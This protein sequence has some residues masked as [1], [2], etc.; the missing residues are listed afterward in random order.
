MTKRKKK[1]ILTIV[2]SLAG[3]VVVLLIASILV[4]RSAWFANY[5]REKII[6]VTEESTGGKVEIASFQFDWTHLTA[7][8][9][10]F[11][12]HGTE[13]PGSDP[14]V[15]VQ[16][17]EV[18][19]KLFA[20]L[21]KAV[22]IQ[23]LGIQQPHVNFI[24]FPDGKTNVPEPKIQKQPSQTSGLQT[25]VDL[26]IGQFQ[27]Q[28]GLLQFS[29]QKT[30]FSARGENLRA[31]LNYNFA[32]PGYQGNLWID[33]LLL[34]SANRPPLNVHVNLPVAM[35]KDAVKIAGAQLTTAQSKILLNGSI[36]HMKAPIV[37]AHLNAN[38]SLPEVQTS[39]A[40]PI[41]ANA[42]GAPKTL[43]ADLAV[44][45][46]QQKNIQLQTA[47]VTLGQTTFEGSGT[48]R[49]ASNSGSGQFN[50]SLALGEL[51]RLFNVSS[52]R[53]TGEL[54]AHGTA[55]IDADNTYFVDGTLNTRDVSIQSGTTR[56]PNVALYSPFHADPYLISLDGLKLGAFGGSL[57]AKIFVENMQRLSVEGDLRGFAL[58]ALAQAFTGKRLGY[59]GTIGGSVKAQ[60]DLKAKGTSGY[61]A[62]V[63]LDIIP[64]NR[65]VPVSGRL[66]A[67]Y[68]G[69]SDTV[70]L[71]RS[72]LA[73]PS[74]RV[75][76]SG[77]LNQRIDVSLSS[78]NLNDFLP[79][80]NFESS[81][82]RQTSLPVTLQGGIAT[83]QAQ[84]TG[85][86]SAPRITS[87]MAMDRFAVEQRSFD[88]LSLDLSASPSAAAVQNGLLTRKALRTNFD[89]SIGLRKWSPASRSAVTA[90]L[91]LRNGDLPDL[92][93]LAGEASLPATGNISANVHIGGTYGNP[94]GSA[95]LQVLNG[96][97]YQ[98]PFD[99]LYTQVNLSDQLVTLSTLELAAGQ[100]RITASGTFQHP[101]D[102]FTVGHAQLH[103]GTSNL[104][105]ANLK[106][107]QREHAGVAGLIQLTADAA[108]DLR[109]VNHQLEVQIANV[110]ADLSGRGLRVQ[111]QNAGDLVASARTV[112]GTVNYNAS[113][114]FA[115]SSISVK[116]NTGLAK[117]Y[118]TTADASI[119][120]LSIEKALSIVGEAGLPARG[121]LSA[122]AH[123]A[124]TIKSPNANLSLTLANAN[125]YTEPIDRL[126]ATLRYSNTLVDIPSLELVAPAGR[127]T[128]A[129]FFAHAAGNF[130]A[131]AVALRVNSSDIQVAKIQHV[132]QE[133]P[134][135]TGVLRLAADL[136]A[137][138]RDQNGK[139]SVLVSNLNADASA[140]ALRLN[141]RNLGQAKFT[142][143]T[144]GGNL[145]FALDSDIAQSRI[146]GS[147]QGQLSGDY[148]LRANL[149][150]SNVKYSNFAPFVSSEPNVA[151]DF[152]GVLE[153]EASV[154]GPLLNTNDLTG[155]LQLN[156]LELMTL[157]HESPTGSPAGRT[158]SFHNEGA[159][160]IALNHSVVQVQQLHMQGPSTTLNA[161]G[162]VNFREAA[163]PLRLRLDA[164]MDLGVLQD[165]SRDFYSSGTVTLATTV[166]G[167]FTQPLVNG[168]IE[169]KNANVNYA[170]A[171]NGLSKANGV[172][173]L[174]GTSASIQNLTA[175]SGGGKIA[176]AGF[177]G[178]TG[179][180][181]NYNLQAT[182]NRV[183]TRYSGISV[184]S[185]AALRLSG[186]S[187]HSLLAGGVTVQR[188]AYESTGDIGSM[189]SNASA[190]P[191]TPGAPSGVIGGVKLD[192]HILTAPDLRV[193]T[194]YAQRLQVEAD[195]TVRGT[196]EN[197]GI[198]GRVAVTNG[199]LVF[200][201]N[202][203]TVNAGTI[204][205]Y[206]PTSIQPIL[207]ISLEANVQGVDVT[208]GVSGP[209]NDLKLSYRSDPP[210]TFEQIVELLAA[211][212]TPTTDPTI[213]AQQPAPAQQSFAQMGESAVLGQAVANPLA[214]RIQ[215]VFGISQ[216]KID[217]SFQ[218]SNG[219]PT[220][221]VTLQQQITSN[222]TFTYITDV[223]QTNSEIIRVE[224]AF[225]PRFSAVALHDYNGNV[226]LEFYYKF[227]IR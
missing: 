74:S 198:I 86:V 52:T 94:L 25:V 176:L 159:I 63:R 64:G 139:P 111:N 191:S 192:I 152:D 141:N 40:L 218:G 85:N 129:G 130:N 75:D 73:L 24:V 190:P 199:Q 120:N 188:I 124:G 65:G 181:L 114:D 36:E 84:I 179:T 164:N 170:D 135:L 180:V 112:D 172:I 29:H 157:P 78:R 38:L 35:E 4:L 138:L 79:A 162:S 168:R 153:G 224:W 132:R 207:N 56:L 32:T 10:N 107:L 58:A 60:G 119:Q 137:N 146:H 22:D 195:L 48:L 222:I 2:A 98:E 76:L 110:N 189:L 88:H 142:A 42:K 149:S 89:A 5:V 100:A 186:N 148:P 71:G 208:I 206:N 61:T 227:K 221:R 217:P 200:F 223:T 19:L 125:V 91:S 3:L 167:S 175:E 182:A 30:A 169:L 113:S 77:S 54:E 127:I 101:R 6:A 213:A 196:A 18:R 106:T 202:E 116:G 171:P 161:S 187:V 214:S 115:G 21:K 166:R 97:A 27:I 219:Q 49:N 203:Y 121:K 31:L 90:N 26:A 104:Q 83:L 147:G 183:R 93:S 109:Q 44:G 53:A 37:S 57:A 212:K 143:H 136:S 45:M 151:P 87:H 154:N 185:S 216:F 14:L 108:A 55:R 102:S 123:I 8:I 215:R 59:D 70:I 204:N 82:P 20:G 105:L 34:S 210:L 50:A 173:L 28:N 128:V 122:N 11:V 126:Q 1:I 144:T 131:G 158:V 174:N 13:P 99:R 62:T 96:S 23:Y 95:T 205:F 92:L 201:G 80:E 41:E 178:F 16:L 160:V 177:V 68:M 103:V 156:R 51:G 39:F 197:P 12:L 140:A 47:R 184:V 194:T 163:A 226:S 145:N 211:N 7:R 117:D 66:D 69:A 33:P 193:I 43:T 209:M 225:T 155:R 118:P 9:R 165:M 81:G 133:K 220:A 15:R 67:D 46:D 150:F 134:G 17:L 72:Y